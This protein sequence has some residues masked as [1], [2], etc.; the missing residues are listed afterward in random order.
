MELKFCNLSLKI[1]SVPVFS[2]FTVFSGSNFLNFDDAYVK[3]SK[4]FP[5]HFFLRFHL[6]SAVGV[7][8][9]FQ[10]DRW[11]KSIQRRETM[12]KQPENSVVGLEEKLFVQS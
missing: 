7:N 6:F 9:F 11:F 10:L 5:P 8:E 4:V 1:P 12:K 3:E 2:L